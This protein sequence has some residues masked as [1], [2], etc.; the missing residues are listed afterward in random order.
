MASVD[1]RAGTANLGRNVSMS[2]MTAFFIAVGGVSLVCF[3][4]MGR[5][6]RMRDRRRAYADSFGSDGG[7]ISSGNTGFSLFNWFGGSSSSSSDDSCTSSSPSFSSGGDSSCSDGGGGG[8]DGG[9][10]GGD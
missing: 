9:G 5:A 3:W 2:G 6:D 7:G 1:I 10:G 4:L 8:G